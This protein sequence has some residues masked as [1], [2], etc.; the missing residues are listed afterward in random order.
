MPQRSSVTYSGRQMHAP[1]DDRPRYDQLRDAARRAVA[2]GDLD[3]AEELLQEAVAEGDADGFA[4]LGLSDVAVARR[5]YLVAVSLIRRALAK[6]PD[7][8]VR[9]GRL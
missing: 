7:D 4:S 5:N 3:L 2:E 1:R 9:H 8:A 6:R